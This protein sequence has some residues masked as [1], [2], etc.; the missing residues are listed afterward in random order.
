MMFVT[1]LWLMESTQKLLLG[2]RYEEFEDY[3]NIK[4]QYDNHKAGLWLGKI[5]ILPLI[6]VIAFSFTA[7]V[8]LSNDSISYKGF[9]DYKMCKYKY[10]DIASISYY[11]NYE[12]R[13]GKINN[14]P[15]FYIRFTDGQKFKTGFYFGGPSKSDSFMLVLSE[16]GKIPIDTTSILYFKDK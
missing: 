3:Y 14:K 7:F 11:E 10:K 9:F 2:Y 12:E 6:V 15:I 8:V 13:N 5:F 1:L 4:Q 16:K